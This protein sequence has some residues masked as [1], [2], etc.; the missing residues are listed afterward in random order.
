MTQGRL[1]ELVQTRVVRSFATFGEVLAM[2]VTA[3]RHLVT[4]IP[5]GR[6][7]WKEF[8]RQAWFMTS[9]SV[10]PTVL[11]AVPFGVIISVQVSSIAQQVGATSFMGAAN[12]LGVIQQGAPIVTAL[13]LAG[14][15]GSAITSDLGARKIREEIDALETMGLSPVRRLVAPRLAAILLVSLVLC[16]VVVFT[17]VVTGYF[18]NVLAQGGTP[19]SYVSSFAAFAQPSDLI[20]AEG[21]SLLFG[22]I[23]GVV[24]SHK[25]LTAKGGPGGV[26][27]AVNAAVVLSVVLLFAVNVVITQLAGLLFPSRIV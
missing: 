14:A 25:G 27:H 18:F 10:L 8:V 19:G 16:G 4:D 13:L 24:A 6:F 9:V 22:G 26:A 1:A 21:K 12:G 23:V 7:A 11:V 5:R 3:T 17:G 20:L 15:V 2:S